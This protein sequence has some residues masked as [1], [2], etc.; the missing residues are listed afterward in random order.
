MT[1]I[2]EKMAKLIVD[3]GGDPENVEGWTQ[4]KEPDFP[5]FL[6]KFLQDYLPTFVQSLADKLFVLQ[7]A[8]DETSFYTSDDPVTL[9]NDTDHGPY[10]KRHG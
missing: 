3:R 2:D 7:L 5:A 9:H 8:P 10:R 1:A 4:F 6:A